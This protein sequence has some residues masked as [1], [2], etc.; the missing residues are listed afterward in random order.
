MTE[1]N[2]F[3]SFYASRTIQL[4]KSNIRNLSH[5]FSKNPFFDRANVYINTTAKCRFVET[6]YTNNYRFELS[7]VVWWKYRST[8]SIHRGVSFM[9]S[10]WIISNED[11]QLAPVHRRLP[12]INS[13]GTIAFIYHHLLNAH[14][15]SIGSSRIVCLCS[16]VCAPRDQ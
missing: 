8:F 7:V 4:K 13:G 15:C 1:G 5:K 9:E 16:K 14:A 3:S 11:Q 10:V 2:S 6:F 12:F